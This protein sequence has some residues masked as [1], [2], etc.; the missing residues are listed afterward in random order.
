MLTILTT[1]KPLSDPN[2]RTAFYNAVGSWQLFQPPP[3][4]LIFNQSPVEIYGCR[5]VTEFLTNETGLPYLNTMLEIA[6]DLAKNNLFMLTSDHLIFTDNL[7][8]AAV[9]VAAQI[10]GPF[11][12]I[13][14]RWELAVEGP[15]GFD[16]DWATSL[17]A[18]AAKEGQPGSPA[19][20]DF[21]IFR[22]GKEMGLSMPPFVLGREWFD[23]WWLNAMLKA[24]YPVIDI[25]CAVIPIHQRHGWPWSDGRAGRAKTPGQYHNEA[26]AKADG[27]GYGMEFKGSILDATHLLTD[28]LEIVRKGARWIKS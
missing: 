22:A 21:F 17:E 19:A 24:G 28:K 27:V 7:T 18:K 3:E 4:I 8:P 9:A 11:L 10:P 16:I 14:P 23:S 12:A 15:L 2:N 13:G 1:P 5:T 26:L 20:K 6:G 25:S